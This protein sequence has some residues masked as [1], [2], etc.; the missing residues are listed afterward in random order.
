[1]AEN[2]EAQISAKEGKETELK[3]EMWYINTIN[4]FLKTHK[5]TDEKEDFNLLDKVKT[6]KPKEEVSKA[7]NVLSGLRDKLKLVDPTEATKNIQQIDLDN[8]DAI[9]DNSVKIIEWM[10]TSL[11]GDN[12]TREDLSKME[13]ILAFV[14]PETRYLGEVKQSIKLHKIN[15]IKEDLNNKNFNNDI[16]N[17]YINKAYK[18]QI[19]DKG[20][21]DYLKKGVK[22]DDNKNA[23]TKYFEDG[24]NP[25]GE[26]KF[27][28]I[29]IDKIF[30]KDYSAIN[31]YNAE[32]NKGLKIDG[33]EQLEKTYKQDELIKS[34]IKVTRSDIL[35]YKFSY[36][37]MEEITKDLPKIIEETVKDYNTT[38]LN[39]NYK[40]R[41]SPD[42]K[43]RKNIMTGLNKLVAKENRL[44]LLQQFTAKKIGEWPDSWKF[45][46]MLKH[47]NDKDVNTLALAIS[48]NSE[49]LKGVRKKVK[50]NP[51]AGKLVRFTGAKIV[52]ATTDEDIW[53]LDDNDQDYNYKA[54]LRWK[55]I[56]N[57]KPNILSEA[58]KGEI[59]KYIG[60]LLKNS[61]VRDIAIQVPK[62][63]EK[64]YS[65]VYEVYW[66]KYRIEERDDISTVKVSATEKVDELQSEPLKLDLLNLDANAIL[67]PKSEYAEIVINNLLMNSGNPD[68]A[69]LLQPES[70]YKIVWWDINWWASRNYTS[71]K[72]IISFDSPDIKKKGLDIQKKGEENSSDQNISNNPGLAY[73]RAGSFLAYFLGLEN[74]AKVKDGAKFNINHTVDGPTRKELTNQLKEKNKKSPSEDQILE[75]FKEWQKASINLNFTKPVDKPIWK[76]FT[77]TPQ[78]MVTWFQIK[79]TTAPEGPVHSEKD[80]NAWTWFERWLAMRWSKGGPTLPAKSWCPMSF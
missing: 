43:L 10:R 14:T 59:E 48:E 21:I 26:N 36:E 34:M 47:T 68:M 6:D 76:E 19:N 16:V 49:I 54:V 50:A 42:S 33:L 72:S 55:E 18:S 46:T 57:S 30:N 17:A 51:E 29:T 69:K 31:I 3:K 13:D 22:T 53:K 32:T 20:L 25:N 80:N 65:Q 39:T 23:I 62:W 41:E 79:I 78:E 27:W 71:Y 66:D 58:T 28:I 67:D 45:E 1:M 2:L 44:Y 56:D 12:P 9:K 63:N 35:K 77:T 38:D 4:A 74:G 15:F 70:G 60:E 52:S 40:K 64:L 37:T 24:L 73:D 5:G 61:N 75:A 8:Q 7:W 11:N